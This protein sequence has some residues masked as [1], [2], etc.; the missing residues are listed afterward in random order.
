M[1]GESPWRKGEAPSSKRAG[2]VL[3]HM[4]MAYRRNRRPQGGIVNDS[5]PRQTPEDP[6]SSKKSRIDREIEEILARSD[7]V[8]PFP[9]QE[10]R[11][12]RP[13]ISRHLGT[14]STSSL[15][16][17]ATQFGTQMLG[18]PIL[19]GLFTAIL[20]FI[21]SG[22]SQLLANLFAFAA[23]SLVLLPIIQRFRRPTSAPETKMWR[24][25]AID[26]RSDESSPISQIKRWWS[27]Q[28][29]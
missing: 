21:I 19:L 1:A 13:S 3:Y 18:A 7:N 4:C 8:L 12:K 22:S 9:P 15:P 20:A 17:A 28:R 2:G 27:S 5:D 24:G 25:Q 23:V 16:D 10:D 14:P 6:D 11:R 26:P 29:G